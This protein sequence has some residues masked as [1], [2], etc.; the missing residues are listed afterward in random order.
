MRE[1]LRALFCAALVLTWTAAPARAKSSREARYS[2]EQ[3]WS[4]A[5]RHLRVN[6]GFQITE[7]DE[8]AG[9]VVFQMK[10]DG[11]LFA[12]ALEV[13]VFKDRGRP[14]VRLVLQIEDRPSYMEDAVLERMVAKLR[15]DHGEPPPPPP[16]RKDKK[17]PRR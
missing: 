11:K 8:E 4:S 1:L 2:F 7:K 15:E 16:P 13:V 10:D 5:V 3:V 14:K 17:A 12:G 6:E 9:Y